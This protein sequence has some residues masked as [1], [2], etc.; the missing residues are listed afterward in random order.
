MTAFLFDVFDFLY[1]SLF[2]AMVAGVVAYCV[3]VFMP[4]ET[5]DEEIDDDG[6]EEAIKE[7]AGC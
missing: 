7:R 2:I 5:S 4:I 6:S 1:K 3:C